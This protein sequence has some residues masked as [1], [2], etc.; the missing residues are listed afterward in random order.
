[1]QGAE[2]DLFFGEGGFNLMLQT[3]NHVCEYIY[4]YT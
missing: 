1:M 4:T 2:L 3:K